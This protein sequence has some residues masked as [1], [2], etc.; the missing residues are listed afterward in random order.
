MTTRKDIFIT[1]DNLVCVEDSLFED[2]KLEVLRATTPSLK[3]WQFVSEEVVMT[4]NY[5]RYRLVVAF[6]WLR[7]YKEVDQ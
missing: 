1:K 5:R 4:N 2:N 6:E 3:G 7:V